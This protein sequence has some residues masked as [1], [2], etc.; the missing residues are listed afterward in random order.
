MEYLITCLVAFLG[1]GLTLFSG[2]GLGTLLIPA[3]ALFFPIEIAI[4]LTAIVHFLNNI[5]KLIL[6]GKHADKEIILRFGIPSVIA[7]FAG[8]YLLTQLTHLQPLADYSLQGKLFFI[9]PVKAMIGALM[10]FF[11]LFDIIPSLA[12]IQFDRKFL[13]LGGVLS[14]FIGG[15]S[16]HQGALRSAFLIRANLTKEV[17]IASGVVIACLTDISRLTVYAGKFFTHKFNYPLII[18]ATLSAFTGAYFGNKF[19]KKITI[20]ALQIIVAVMLIV[21]GVL[22]I[23]GI[24]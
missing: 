1:S 9:T 22:L 5:F 17:F 10:I 16:G 11:A 4:A 12:N 20:K 21:F 7:A 6:L 14:G 3:F 2:F 24:L 8:A 19:V 13:P 23:L 15:L 18:A